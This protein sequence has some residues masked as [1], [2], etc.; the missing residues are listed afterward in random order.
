MFDFCSACMLELIYTERVHVCKLKVL[1][2]FFY[3]P[4]VHKGIISGGFAS[5]LFSNIE[6]IFNLHRKLPAFLILSM[7]FTR[8]IAELPCLIIRKSC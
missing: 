8:G 1:L 2:K 5:V 4:L 6:V 3:W 7:L